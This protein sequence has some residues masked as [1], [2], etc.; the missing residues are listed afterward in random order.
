ML[1]EGLMLMW[2]P[3]QAEESQAIRED[4]INPK[5]V[6]DMGRPADF[7][8]MAVSSVLGMCPVG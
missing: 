2:K 5:E 4:A 6:E 1:Q 8:D 7:E 3:S